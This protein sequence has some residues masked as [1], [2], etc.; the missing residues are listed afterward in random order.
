MGIGNTIENLKEAA[1][2]ENDEWTN[3][4]PRM[5]KEAREEG[6]EEIAKLFEGIAEIE[7]HHEERFKALLKN[8]EEG[9]VFKKDGKVYWKC[10]NCGYI[11]EAASAP[12]K[13]P[14]CVHP[15]AYFEIMSNNY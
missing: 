5:A 6:F 7:K 2:G 9:T 10:R 12:D 3:M 11:H 13:C 4:Y 15:Q 14:V 1:G 8:I